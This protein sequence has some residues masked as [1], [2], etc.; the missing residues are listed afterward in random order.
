MKKSYLITGI[1]FCILFAFLLGNNVFL[2][3]R[4]NRLD[5]KV[6]TIQ[7]YA[8]GMPSKKKKD[9][10]ESKYYSYTWFKLGSASHQIVDR[11]FYISNM[12]TV[13]R[14]N[15]FEISGRI[16]NIT[17]MSMNIVS[18]ECAVSDSTQEGRVIILPNI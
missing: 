6:D 4:I 9:L 8:W 12:Q 5:N 10:N 13:Y 11:H 3:F 2:I 15:G 14:E 18:I 16:G 1:V 7:K 17:S